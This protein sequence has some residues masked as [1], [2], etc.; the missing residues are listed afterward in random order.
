MFVQPFW[1]LWAR[2]FFKHFG[3]EARLLR[4][5]FGFKA[6]LSPNIFEYKQALLPN[7]N[8]LTYTILDLKHDFCS[9]ILGSKQEFRSSILN[10]KQELWIRSKSKQTKLSSFRSKTFVVGLTSRLLLK[11]HGFE[12]LLFKRLESRLNICSTIL[13]SELDPIFCAK[14]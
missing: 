1:I 6:R 4:K 12:R 14:V 11:K 5:K 3:F 10:Y 8:V 7:Q 9:N 2:L 13:D